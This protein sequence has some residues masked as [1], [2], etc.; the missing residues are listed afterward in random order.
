MMYI[1]A[2][3]GEILAQLREEERRRRRAKPRTEIS[4]DM[5]AIVGVN[6]KVQSHHKT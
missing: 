1:G 6:T 4:T 3:T 2:L 5:S